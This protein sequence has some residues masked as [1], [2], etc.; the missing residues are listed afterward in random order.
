MFRNELT[1]TDPV[2]EFI[3]FLLGITTLRH[4]RFTMIGEGSGFIDGERSVTA[5]SRGTLTGSQG[6]AKQEFLISVLAHQ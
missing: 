5:Q 1:E 4:Q 2:L 3:L 6:V